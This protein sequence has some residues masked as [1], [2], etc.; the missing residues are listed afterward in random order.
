MTRC[1]V[2]VTFSFVIHRY[3]RRRETA[4]GNTISLTINSLTA[5]LGCLKRLS[6]IDPVLSLENS[7][8]DILFCTGS[9]K[10]ALCIGYNYREGAIY[11]IYRQRGHAA[12]EGFI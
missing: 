3:I 7:L 11:V 10:D 2:D 1:F 9:L 8:L 12:S 5:A 4:R 6:L